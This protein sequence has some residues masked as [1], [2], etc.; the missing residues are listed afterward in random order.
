[1]KIT[2][3]EGKR[4]LTKI[5]KEMIKTK[6]LESVTEIRPTWKLYISD[7]GFKSVKIE[8]DEELVVFGPYSRAKHRVKVF[9]TLEIGYLEKTKHYASLCSCEYINKILQELAFSVPK[10]KINELIHVRTI[11]P[12]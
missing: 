10:L 7:N 3:K 2:N 12:A 8:H 6:M 11:T 1:M 4:V 5:F 9:D